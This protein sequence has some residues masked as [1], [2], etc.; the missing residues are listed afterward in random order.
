MKLL[1]GG[2]QPAPVTPRPTGTALLFVTHDALHASAGHL[3][4]VPLLP[5]MFA[6]TCCGQVFA[7]GRED[8][9]LDRVAWLDYQRGWHPKREVPGHGRWVFR[10]VPRKLDKVE[11][12][13]LGHTVTRGTFP[14]TFYVW[15]IAPGDRLWLIDNLTGRLLDQPV[16]TYECRHVSPGVLYPRTDNNELEEDE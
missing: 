8:A 3:E 5:G 1:Q 14:E 12:A 10:Q 9:G 6:G 16:S 7:T 13:W 4:E 2:N 11:V 15:A